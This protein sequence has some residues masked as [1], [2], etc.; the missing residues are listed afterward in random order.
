MTGK[1]V[2]YSD[3]EALEVGGESKNAKIRWL[4]DDDHDGAPVYSLRMVE[5]GEGG[6]SPK[7]THAWEHENFIVEGT[8]QVF[9]NEEW[10]DLN[11]GDV[12][13]VPPNTMHQYRNSGKSTFK[14]L[15]GIPVKDLLPKS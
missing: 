5:L 8:G 6:Y 14:F 3:V 4:I 9:L 10:K 7:H 12:V 15:C 13:F 1:V 11:P 2:H